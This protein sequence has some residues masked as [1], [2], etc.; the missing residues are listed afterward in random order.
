MPLSKETKP[1]LKLL[2]DVPR[3]VKVNLAI[4]KKKTVMNSVQTKGVKKG[5]SEK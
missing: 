4:I 2:T 3:F 1:N 5:S